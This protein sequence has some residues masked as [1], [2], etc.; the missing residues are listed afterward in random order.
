VLTEGAAALVGDSLTE[1]QIESLEAMTE[2]VVALCDCPEDL[3]GRVC[4]SL[5]LI[6]E[7]GLTVYD[8]DGANPVTV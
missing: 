3:T 2:A 6:A 7:L 5:D 1:D 8:L 4:V